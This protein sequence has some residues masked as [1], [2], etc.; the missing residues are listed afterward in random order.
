LPDHRADPQQRLDG[1]RVGFEQSFKKRIDGQLGA[2]DVLHEAIV[3]F[4]GEQ[5]TFAILQRYQLTQMLLAGT[6]HTSPL[7]D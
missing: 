6:S 1:L 7:V 5:A 2:Y 4:T 3:N